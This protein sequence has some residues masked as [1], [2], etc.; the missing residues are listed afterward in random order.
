MSRDEAVYRGYRRV[1]LEKLYSHR[2]RIEG[3]DGYL[4]RWPRESAAARERLEVIPDL[5]YG[6]RA[7]ESCD[8]FP[9]GPGAPVQVFFHGGYW[10]S[11]DK[12]NFEF[13]APACVARGAAFVSAN[14]PLCPEVTLPELVDACRRCVV[15]VRDYAP[16]WGGDPERV[17]VSGHSAGGHIAACLMSTDWESVRPGLPGD[18]VKGA[19]AI[20]G[21]Y[22]LEA[23]RYLEVNDTLRI[24]AET[25]RDCS[26][27]LAVPR[28]G[29][30]MVLAVGTGEGGEFNRQQAAYAAAWRAGGHACRAM[31]LDGE[32][33]FSILDRFA[34]EGSDLFE[35]VCALMGE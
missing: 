5:A 26:P 14:Y 7:A 2:H 33:H 12:R 31:V 19:A 20:S 3:Y 9:A 16:G 30:P 29:G 8:V 21:L 15:Y 24:D 4:E 34:C 18:L 17:F 28:A 10:H 6:K 23:L 13:M 32:N 22:D 11:Q 27:L 35:A 25:A 1:E